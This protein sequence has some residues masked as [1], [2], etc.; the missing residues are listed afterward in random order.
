MS[1]GESASMGLLPEA[2]AQG[3]LLASRGRMYDLTLAL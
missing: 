2:S 3:E 1:R